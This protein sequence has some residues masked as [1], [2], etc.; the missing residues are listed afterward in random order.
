M[1]E[2]KEHIQVYDKLIKLNPQV[3]EFFFGRAVTKHLSGDINGA[4]TDLKKG[5]N[6]YNENLSY[7]NTL[8]DN[9][10]EIVIKYGMSSPEHLR[11]KK[12]I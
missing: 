1:T 11:I 12:Q 6:L 10:R 2:A 8:K 4:L 3:S 9:M 7:C 5:T